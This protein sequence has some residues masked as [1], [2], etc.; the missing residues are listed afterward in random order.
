MPYI[1][2]KAAQLDGKTKVGSMQCVALVQHYAHVPNTVYWRAGALVLDNQA[3]A[4]GTA[5]ATFVNGR[6][7]NN[8]HGNHAAF[9]LQHGLHGFWVIDQWTNMKNKPKISKRF[10]RL[11]AHNPDGTWSRPSDNAGAF[12]VIEGR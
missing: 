12:S 3:I 11:Q 8:A 10:I 7:Q 1:Y 5:I 9:F 2:A 4:P 6:Y